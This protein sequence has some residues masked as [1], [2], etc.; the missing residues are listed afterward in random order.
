MLDPLTIK[1]QKKAASQG[2]ALLDE[3]RPNWWLEID[4]AT[5]NMDSCHRCILG[6]LFGE[7]TVSYSQGLEALGLNVEA[8]E[9]FTFGFDLEC[10][11]DA[12][13]KYI[14]FDDDLWDGLRD[15][16]IDEIKRRVERGQLS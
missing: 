15:C 1:A 10:Y 13:G 11:K 7:K 9:S 2:A 12:D 16:W 6:Q 4:P 8:E 14:E 3:K 5:L